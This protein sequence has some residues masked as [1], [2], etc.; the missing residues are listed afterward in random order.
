MNELTLDDHGQVAPA[1]VVVLHNNIIKALRKAYP[2]WADH[3]HI[4]INT[5]GG[6]VQI[7]NRLIS[8]KM[9]FILHI[10]DIDTKMRKVVR[11]AGELFERY[12]IARKKGIDIR[13]AM[14]D[15]K[16]SGIGEAVY[17]GD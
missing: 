8:G 16:R 6:V 7:T 2:A 10:A 14:A 3:W 1:G 13:Q 12:D 9:G 15:L 5:E 11:S 17:F 4:S